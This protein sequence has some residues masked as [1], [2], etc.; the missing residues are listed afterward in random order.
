VDNFNNAAFLPHIFGF[1]L[2]PQN[3]HSWLPQPS[4]NQFLSSETQRHITEPAGQQD[5]CASIFS[6]WLL[7]PRLLR[8]LIAIGCHFDPFSSASSASN[9]SPLHKIG[10]Y[11]HLPHTVAQLI[12]IL[13]L[14]QGS[15][16]S[17]VYFNS[18]QMR[19]L[20]IKEDNVKA[21]TWY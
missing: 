11:D 17:E 15:I 3:P 19:I 16:K 8:I 6:L 10:P 2:H 21:Y 13:A 7:T 20:T 14:L 1:T 5:L 18:A 12:H 4:M 9:S